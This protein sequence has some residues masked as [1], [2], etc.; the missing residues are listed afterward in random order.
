MQGKR[1]LNC[2]SRAT[3]ALWCNSRAWAGCFPTRI[4]GRAA[5]YGTRAGKTPVR[6]FVV[7][8]ANPEIPFSVSS[9]LCHELWVNFGQNA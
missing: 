7:H 4:R 3:E 2:K 5:G 9:I 8:P 1:V 6:Q